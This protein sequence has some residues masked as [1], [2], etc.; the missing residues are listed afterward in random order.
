MI[1]VTTLPAPRLTEVGPRDGLE[2]ETAVVPVEAR[3]AF[4][5]A[6]SDTGVREISAGAFGSQTI[7]PQLADSSE[8]F[9]NMRRKEGV[10]YLALVLDEKGLDAALEAEVDKIEVLC[11]ASET[12]AMRTTGA[13]IA[14]V[15]EKLRPLVGRARKA[16]LPV[17]AG[18]A[19]AFH[20]PHEGPVK[21]HSVSGVVER[22][23]AM[24]VGE[25]SLCDT[26]G[27]AS[28]QDVRALLD[29][30]LKH[31]HAE[32]IFLHFHDTYGMALANALTAW[33]EYRIGGFDA[34][35]GGV[36]GC[37]F[38]PGVGGNVATEDLAFAFLSSGAPIKID[39]Q[40]LRA[41]GQALVPHLGHPL[42][43]HLSKI[44]FSIRTE[45]RP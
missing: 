27:R 5:D 19:T 44:D 10:S 8:V 28:P 18:V 13:P 41:A 4:I 25:F 40:K 29:G 20:C 16:K 21:P 39:F 23:W 31:F 45:T 43:S 36:G 22:L 1:D 42:P 35:C 12:F 2:N 14:Q 9:E 15:L 30:M 33:T 17:R 11:P 32:Q 26:L 7:V 37:P 38:A 3:V 34:S 24:G 6:L